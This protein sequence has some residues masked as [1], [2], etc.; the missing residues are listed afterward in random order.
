M[1]A[2]NERLAL[3][4]MD[5][6]R[7][8]DLVKRI[9]HAVDDVEEVSEALAAAPSGNDDADLLAEL[10]KLAKEEEEK[11]ESDTDDELVARLDKL[12]I[13]QSTGDAE[14]VDSKKKRAVMM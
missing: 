4:E 3:P 13:P 2:L 12:R 8:D 11:K 1:A 10:E 14:G 5:A 6:D 7:V 9:R